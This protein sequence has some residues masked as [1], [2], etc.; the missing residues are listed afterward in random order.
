MKNKH[1]LQALL[2]LLIFD[3]LLV[4]TPFLMLQ[5]FLQHTVRTASD[6][7]VSIFG[8]ELPT[9]LAIALVIVMVLLVL[10]IRKITL[11]RTV[12]MIVIFF[13]MYLGQYLS[14][15]YIDYKFYDL[16]NNWH[17]FAYGLFA[18]VMY[19]Y[20]RLFDVSNSKIIIATFL[21]A[22]LISAFDEGIQV[23]ISN[24]IFD[25]SDIAK[26]LWGVTLGIIILFFVVFQGEIAKNGWKIRETRFSDYLK[27]P[28]ALI[29]F[30]LIFAFFL[31]FYSSILTDVSYAF[32]IFA[33]TI[34]SFATVFLIIHFTQY[35]TVKIIFFSTAGI[36]VFLQLFYFISFKSEN[37]VYNAKYLTVYKGLVLPYFDIMIFPD[38]SFRFVDKKTEFKGGDINTINKIGADI[39]LVGSG[40]RAQGGLGFPMQRYVENPHFIYNPN[41][42]KGMQLIK[43]PTPEAIKVY[44]RLIAN[45]KKVV[46][47]IHNE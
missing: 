14:D 27:N 18:F 19:R 30:E 20:L 38:Q 45:N 36:L 21:K 26:D 17:Y 12:V 2:N 44:N 8:I 15:F 10:F 9:V 24:R 1:T 33:F 16:Q 39:L 13:L 34:V 46:F 5:N 41:T 35:K 37:I 31:L 28:L 42:K 3:A 43:L 25:I 23:F 29:V 6:Y 4:L 32:H 7:Y 47:I 40:S 11:Y 22:L